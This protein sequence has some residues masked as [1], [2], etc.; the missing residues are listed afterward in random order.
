MFVRN[1]ARVLCKA[2]QRILDREIEIERGFCC[3]S[4][5]SVYLPTVFI[6]DVGGKGGS[7]Y[8]DLHDFQKR[9]ARLSFNRVG[10]DFMCNEILSKHCIEALV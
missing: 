9:H 3:L 2:E 8:T 10:T 6:C 7:L 5:Y 1:R 4:S